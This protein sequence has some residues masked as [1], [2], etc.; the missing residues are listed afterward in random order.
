MARVG[1]GIDALELLLDRARQG[2]RSNMNDLPEAVAPSLGPIKT[3]QRD[4]TGQTR[5]LAAPGA[6]G[7]AAVVIALWAAHDR[8]RG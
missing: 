1:Q 6:I 7:T 8:R 4:I 3:R 5:T 2:E